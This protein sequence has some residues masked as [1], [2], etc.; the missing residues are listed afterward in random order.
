MYAI[1]S[2]YES[3]LVYILRSRM[4]PCGGERAFIGLDGGSPF[5]TLRG[6]ENVAFQVSSGDHVLS[7][8]FEMGVPSVQ[9]FY[10]AAGKSYYLLI[11]PS[12]PDY[13]YP[14]WRGTCA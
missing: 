2:Y 5:V 10:F 7:T 6:G 4:A 3:A 8:A 13:N 12:M 1:R 9:G 11:R 14:Y